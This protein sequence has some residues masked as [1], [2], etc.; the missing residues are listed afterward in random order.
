MRSSACDTFSR[1]WPGTC[2]P[3]CFNLLPD[4]AQSVLCRPPSPI[5]EVGVIEYRFKDWLQSIDQ[6]LLAHPIIDRRDAEQA[7][8]AWLAHLWD[9]LLPHRSWR[10]LVGA[11]LLVQSSET[12]FKRAA[13]RLDAFTVNP[14]SP[15]VGFDALPRDLQVLRLVDFVDERVNF[16]APVGLIQSASLLGR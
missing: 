12:L 1:S 7:P 2:F 15:V 14:A 9:A 8:L 6:C 13:K 16:L 3:A 11:K 4:L 10:V 5:S